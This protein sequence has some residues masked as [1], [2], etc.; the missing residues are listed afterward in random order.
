[1]YKLQCLALRIHVVSAEKDAE[2]T[3]KALKYFYIN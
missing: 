2:L 1:M 3:H